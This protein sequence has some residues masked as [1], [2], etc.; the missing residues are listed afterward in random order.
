MKYSIFLTMLLLSFFVSLILYHFIQDRKLLKTVT[1]VYRGTRTERLMVLKLLKFGIPHQTIFHDLYLKKRGSHYCQIDLVVATK[2]GIVV[3]EVKKYN[4]WI[5]GLASETHWTQVLAYG[6]LRYKFYNPILQNKNHI[7]DLKEQLPQF[8]N[9]P[10][11]SLIVFFG[12][13]RFKNLDYVPENTFI[14]KSNHVLK[15]FNEILEQNPIVKYDNKKEIVALLK[16]ASLNG[17][18]PEIRE[19]HIKNIKNFLGYKQ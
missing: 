7:K 10:F 4:G 1:S 3:F 12:D 19:K 5:F 16:A 9:V 13:C 17:Q 8:Q 11:Y 15:M 2:V 6:K 14:V 18:N